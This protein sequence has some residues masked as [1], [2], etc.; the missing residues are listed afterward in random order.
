MVEGS[1]KGKLWLRDASKIGRFLMLSADFT[2][3]IKH[4]NIEQQSRFMMVSA[5][6]GRFKIYKLPMDWSS[7]VSMSLKGKEHYETIL[8]SKVTVEEENVRRP[9]KKN[10]E[11]NLK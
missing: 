8:S 6:D 3:K 11:K 4:I 9:S 1:V 10:I 7:E 5:K 2:D